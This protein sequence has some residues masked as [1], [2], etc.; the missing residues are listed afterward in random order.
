MTGSGK[1]GAG[2]AFVP[3]FRSAL[4]PGYRV[5]GSVEPP[6]AGSLVTGLTNVGCAPVAT[7]FR[8]AAK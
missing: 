3:G 7:K 4:H 6:Y 2:F 5:K 8:A 1:S